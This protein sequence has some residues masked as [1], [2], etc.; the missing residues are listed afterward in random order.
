MIVTKENIDKVPK[1]EQVLLRALLA[2]IKQDINSKIKKELQIIWIDDDYNIPS[3]DG[4]YQL[5][6]KDSDE[7]I[8][9][10]STI[11]QLDY[12]IC[13]LCNFVEEY[14]SFLS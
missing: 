10:E 4:Y 12:T 8:G 13:A 2:D 5:K 6:F 14:S 1:E 7:T 9:V 3:Y 11:H